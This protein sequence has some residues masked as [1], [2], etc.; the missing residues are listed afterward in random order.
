MPK[1]VRK[2]HI[3]AIRILVLCRD[4][5]LLIGPF[6]QIDQLAAFAAEGTK[7]T[8][9]IPEDW[10]AA[11][12]A[13]NFCNHTILSCNRAWSSDSAAGQLEG[14]I[15]GFQFAQGEKA[16]GEPALVAAHGGVVA[17][18]RIHL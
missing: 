16:Q 17:L 5:P 2:R 3:A 13:F 1:F 15:T 18:S 12:W 9:F 4:P 8:L 11:G 7:G 14:D 6:A 10:L